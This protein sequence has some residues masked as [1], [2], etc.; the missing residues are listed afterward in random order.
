[1][2][3]G[4][5]GAEREGSG[6]ALLIRGPD[7]TDPEAQSA[8]I[9]TPRRSRWSSAS[10]REEEEPWAFLVRVTKWAAV[11]VRAHTWHAPTLATGQRPCLINLRNYS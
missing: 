2:Q 1:M 10:G 4:P 8:E 3:A 6:D 11:W 7:T 9:L 5:T